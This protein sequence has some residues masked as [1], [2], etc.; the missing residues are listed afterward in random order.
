[1]RRLLQWTSGKSGEVTHRCIQGQIQ[2]S[3]SQPDDMGDWN[4]NR[5]TSALATSI[6]SRFN[7]LR[8]ILTRVEQEGFLY[9]LP[10][11]KSQE[12]VEMAHQQ[13]IERDLEVRPSALLSHLIIQF[14]IWV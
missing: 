8:V 14:W 13:G 6:S 11:R 7:L 12:G 10:A 2:T 9:S 5:A 1:M 4:R 3:D